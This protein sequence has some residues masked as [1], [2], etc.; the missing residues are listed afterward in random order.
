MFGFYRLAAASPE[1]R[2]ADPAFNSEKIIET[3]L[4]AERHHAA[5]VLF[6]ELAVS[7][8]TCADLFHQPFPARLKIGQES[9]FLAH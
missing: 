4:T 6:P 7:G 1:L 8:Y 9:P 5:A 2:V 3:A